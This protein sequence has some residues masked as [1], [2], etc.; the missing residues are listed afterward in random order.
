MDADRFDSLTRAL[1]EARTRRGTLAALLGGTLGLRGLA[2]VDAKN[3]KK[4]GNKKKRKACL[5]KAKNKKKPNC[6]DLIPCGD[7]CCARSES[8]CGNHCCLPFQTCCGTGC[9]SG[10]ESCR[11]GVCVNHCND[12]VQNFRETDTDCGGSCRNVRKCELA[13]ACAEDADCETEVCVDRPGFG[14]V[15]LPC[16]A[17]PDCARQNSQTPFCFDNFCADCRTSEDCPADKRCNL[18]T[19]SCQECVSDG[20]CRN[21]ERPFC[22]APLDGE[23]RIAGEELLCVCRGCRTNDD[24][25]EAETCDETNTCVPRQP[26]EDDSECGDGFCLDCCEECGDGSHCF[27]SDVCP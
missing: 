10:E 23:C 5:K 6:F 13:Q 1:T 20:D 27:A 25:F 15:C 3:C 24:C 2:D 26:C 9:C 19:H 14:F 12:G 17:D 18:H 11:N 7:A 4:I 16:R 8:C 22:V 21:T